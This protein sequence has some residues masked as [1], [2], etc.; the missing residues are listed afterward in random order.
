MR[1]V[2][3]V[4]VK[5]AVPIAKGCR[6]PSKIRAQHAGPD[7]VTVWLLHFCAELLVLQTCGKG[8]NVHP[9]CDSAIIMNIVAD[10]LP[11]VS[12]CHRSQKRSCI[13]WHEAEEEEKIGFGLAETFTSS[14][15]PTTLLH[16]LRERLTLT[17]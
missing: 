6:F 16:S 3:S 13:L 8:A 7:L 4:F 5:H 9:R 12:P 14:N 15:K 10:G 2:L 17:T 11:L 1:T